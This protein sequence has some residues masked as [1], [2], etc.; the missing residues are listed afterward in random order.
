MH[1]QKPHKMTKDCRYKRRPV[2]ALCEGNIVEPNPNLAARAE[3]SGIKI[4]AGW[5]GNDLVSRQPHSIA[6]DGS[7]TDYLDAVAAMGA[8]VVFSRTIVFEEDAFLVTSTG[9][10]E[11]ESTQDVLD[12]RTIGTF[13]TYTEYLGMESVVRLMTIL[14]GVAYTFDH[15]AEWHA[16][17]S[18]LFDT[19][20]HEIDKAIEELNRKAEAAE[21]RETDRIKRKVRALKGDAKVRD[22]VKKRVTLALLGI[23]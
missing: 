20:R 6:I 16:D 23:L 11:V 3:K 7:L 18:K 14:D 22:L 8:R 1:I 13:S 15:D 19:H 21:K 2:Y 10:A 4:V 5:H 12:L 17:F 9:I